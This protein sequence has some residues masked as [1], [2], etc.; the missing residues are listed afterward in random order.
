M[1]YKLNIEPFTWVYVVG[2][3]FHIADIASLNLFSKKQLLDD[4]TIDTTFE[5]VPEPDNPYSTSGMAL[6]VRKGGK[7]LGYL[8]DDTEQSIRDAIARISASG[9]TATTTGT[10][11][12][13]ETTEGLRASIK[14]RLPRKFTP[15]SLTGEGLVPIAKT[16]SVPKAYLSAQ[17]K[18]KGPSAGLEWTAVAVLFILFGSIPVVGAPIALVI[19]IAGI[20]AIVKFKLRFTDLNKLSKK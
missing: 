20:V 9:M 3:S 4:I 6:S 8:A 16:Y 2:E 11:W 1:N 19:L 13:S 7:V 5:I 18:A 12:M 17:P 10:L 14:I 15:E